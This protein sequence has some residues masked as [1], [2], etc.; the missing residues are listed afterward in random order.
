MATCT[1]ALIN[2]HAIVFG[3]KGLD[4]Q[5]IN[6]CW[7]K[8]FIKLG[9]VS[10]KSIAYVTGYVLKKYT[11]KKNKEVYGDFERQP[12]FQL[13]SAGL[14]LRYALDNA[15]MLQD[16]MECKYNG[17]SVGIPRYYQKKL[18]LDT[19]IIKARGLEGRYSKALALFDRAGVKFSEKYSH[20][21]IAD[22]LDLEIY[23]GRSR[24]FDCY[25]D[26]LKQ[27]KMNYEAKERK[28]KGIF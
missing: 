2:Y 28:N 8:G 18:E 16:N 17:R 1:V 24:V 26:M 9:G 25:C 10:Q 23:F 6:E 11:K 14:G 20:Q 12:P 4:E 19:D 5:V 15:D 3:L 13:V 21:R 27:M 22:K 7:N